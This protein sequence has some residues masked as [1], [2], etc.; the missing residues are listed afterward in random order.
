MDF[1]Q[2]QKFLSKLNKNNNRD[3]FEKNKGTYLLAK[4]NFEDFVARF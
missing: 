3:W 4:Q 2:I 1:E